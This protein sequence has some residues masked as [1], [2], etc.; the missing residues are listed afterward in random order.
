MDEHSS[1][2]LMTMRVA[3]DGLAQPSNE[4]NPLAVLRSGSSTLVCVTEWQSSTNSPSFASVVSLPSSDADNFTLQIRH[5]DEAFWDEVGA[6]EKQ[7]RALPLLGSCVF[8][9][10][11]AQDACA[12]HEPLMLAISA[13]PEFPPSSQTRAAAQQST[14]P[15]TARLWFAVPLP[16]EPWSRCESLSLEH[17]TANFCFAAADGTQELRVTEHMLCCAAGYSVPRAALAMLCEDA[18]RELLPAASGGHGGGGGA[19]GDAAAAAQGA[20]AGGGGASSAL[21]DDEADPWRLLACLSP[22]GWRAHAQWLE[23]HRQ[24]LRGA[25]QHEE[26]GFKVRLQPSSASNDSSMRLER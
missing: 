23:Q 22:G 7:L 4:L 11:A 1:G 18:K 26:H 3:I 10:I 20:G 6:T 5:V 15:A 21:L 14:S 25:F 16:G 24:L 9:R 12:A 13:P 2:T 19:D 17:S 8:T